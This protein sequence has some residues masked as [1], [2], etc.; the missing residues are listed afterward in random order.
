MGMRLT[1]HPFCRPGTPLV[2]EWGAGGNGGQCVGSHKTGECDSR[3]LMEKNDENIA[4]NKSYC[5]I[6]FVSIIHID[7]MKS[8][9][10]AVLFPVCISLLIVP[11]FSEETDEERILYGV[12]NL[13]LEV[14]PTGTA[15]YGTKESMTEY[16]SW[17]EAC[18]FQMMGYSNRLLGVLGL[19]GFAWPAVFNSASPSAVTHAAPTTG[20]IAPPLPTTKPMIKPGYG[21][22]TIATI[23]G[24]SGKNTTTVMI[25]YGYW[26][27]WYTADPLLTGGQDSRSGRGSTSALFP[28]LMI[29]IS[30]TDND[31]EV[32]IVEPPGGLDYTLWRRAGD[33]RPWSQKFYNGNKEFT[34]DITARHV[35]SYAIEVRARTSD[36][37]DLQVPGPS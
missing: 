21:L 25:P 8:W 2:I 6:G 35:K 19:T 27:L 37:G 11:V 13:S 16:Q 23:T 3:G 36:C 26:E 12:Q 22:T 20:D 30:K 4:G 29:V 7:T 24:G 18:S 33:P 28:V 34:F 17:L 10:A 9:Y 31:E 32:E 1:P 5:F 14:P 15:L